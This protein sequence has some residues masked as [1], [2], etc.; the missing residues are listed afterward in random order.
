VSE[1]FTGGRG[2]A[3]SS[4]DSVPAPRRATSG[5]LPLALALALAFTVAGCG[6]STH[7]GRGDD[8]DQSAGDG[9]ADA[10]ADGDARPECPEGDQ[11]ILGDPC[12]R[13]EQCE[14]PLCGRQGGV[15]IEE[16][17]TCGRCDYCFFTRTPHAEDPTLRCAAEAGRCQP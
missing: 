12:T 8:D 13:Q 4:P 15:C 7:G 1:M 17:W 10:D 6:F 5:F 2:C 9:D 3:R 16:T 11:L 14:A